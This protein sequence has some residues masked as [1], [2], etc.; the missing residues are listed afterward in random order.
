MVRK[1]KTQ[2]NDHVFYINGTKTR[3]QTYT[4][5]RPQDKISILTERERKYKLVKIRI[6]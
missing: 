6:E 2:S 4:K 5:E 1:D 3:I